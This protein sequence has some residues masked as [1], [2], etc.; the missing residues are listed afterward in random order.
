MLKTHASSVLLILGAAILGGC[1]PVVA[2]FDGVRAA[3]STKSVSLVG[4]PPANALVM[5]EA[6][7]RTPNAISDATVRSAGRTIGAEWVT[8]E[9]IDLGEHTTLEGQ[10][11]ELRNTISGV[12]PVGI[13]VPTQRTWFEYIARFYQQADDAG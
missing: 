11:I 12:T 9:R 5:G 7:F 4:E 3:H 1:N 2:N 13:R 8:I 10:T 6:R